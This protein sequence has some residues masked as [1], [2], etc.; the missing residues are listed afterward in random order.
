MDNSRSGHI[1]FHTGASANADT[2]YPF[3]VNSKVKIT[4]D[5]DVSADIL[6]GTFK[7]TL[8]TDTVTTASIGADQVTNAKIADNQIDS[9]HYVDG[10]I[11]TVHIANDQVTAAKIN[12]DVAGPGLIPNGGALEVNPDGTHLELSGDT[13]RIKDS[14][15]TTAKIGNL[16]VT[17]A[18]IANNTITATQINS[19]AVG[20]SELANDAVDTAAI[21][22]TAVTEAKLHTS[23]AGDGLAGGGGT[24]LNVK[25][26]NSTIEI[27]GDTLR[28]KGTG[29]SQIS[30]GAIT[31]AKLASSAVTGDKLAGTISGAKTFSGSVN[32]SGFP[33]VGGFE[34]QPAGQ[35]PIGCILAWLP[36][37][38]GIPGSINSNSYHELPSGY[39]KLCDGTNVSLSGSPMNGLAS[40]NLNGSGD[41]NRRFLRGS[42]SSIGTTG[43]NHEHSHNA[44]HNNKGDGNGS[45]RWGNKDTNTKTHI[46]PHMNVKY[47]IRVK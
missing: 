12:D 6:N 11:D 18:K 42:N 17:A 40:P 10:S 35:V 41:S 15:V 9:E 46:P 32:F 2:T 24:A 37:F 4:G 33:T 7:G 8:H 27:T 30:D 23:V 45:P 36:G 44:A 26:D 13:V 34:L 43:G 21:A 25:V 38:N 19:N 16:Q 22:S 28:V 5:L 29:T 39:W 14:G 1:A 31:T 3:W 20:A 47:I